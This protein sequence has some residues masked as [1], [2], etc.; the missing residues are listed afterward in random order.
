LLLFFDF[1]NASGNASL[2]LIMVANVAFGQLVFSLSLAVAIVRGSQL[3]ASAALHRARLSRIESLVRH[4]S[5][6]LLQ[7][8]S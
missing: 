7:A 6:N 8:L 5:Y 2:Q 3:N 4:R 1:A